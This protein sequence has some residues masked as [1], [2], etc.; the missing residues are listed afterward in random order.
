MHARFLP[1]PTRDESEGPSSGHNT[2]LATCC[3]IRHDFHFQAQIVKY[4]PLQ[5][6]YVKYGTLKKDS[7]KEKE[8]LPQ[9]A[10]RFL[11]LMVN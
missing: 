6:I 9:L 10:H 8:H 1:A 2:N 7:Q 5:Y 4:K 3:V 11:F